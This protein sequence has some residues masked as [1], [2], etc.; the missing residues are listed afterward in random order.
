MMGFVLWDTGISLIFG[1]E[2]RNGDPLHDHLVCTRKNNMR[3]KFCK[4]VQVDAMAVCLYTV[5]HLCNRS[6]IS[7]FNP[8]LNFCL[9]RPLLHAIRPAFSKILFPFTPLTEEHVSGGKFLLTSLFI[10]ISHPV[11]C[12]YKKFSTTSFHVPMMAE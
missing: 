4:E 11:V 7:T 3:E 1:L 10:F 6:Q 5:K 8:F 12:T 9:F 2:K